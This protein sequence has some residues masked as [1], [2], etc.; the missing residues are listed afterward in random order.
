[1][2]NKSLSN[3][4]LE[5]RLTKR[6]DAARQ[7]VV[8]RNDIIRELRIRGLSLRAI[9]EL[10]GLSHTQVGNIVKEDGEEAA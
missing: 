7:T 2:A 3:K 9:G 6:S 8:E 1:M 4:V 10:A 5:G